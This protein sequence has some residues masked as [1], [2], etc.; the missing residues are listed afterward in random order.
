[1]EV[2]VKHLGL[3][4]LQAITCATKEGARSLRL[5][6][7]VGVI[8]KGQLADVIVVDQDP[9]QDIRVLND[10]H[11]LTAVIS[12]GQSV[13]LEVPWPSRALYRGEKVVQWTGTPLTRELAMSIDPGRP[14]R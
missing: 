7:R 11:R 4:P 1:M 8:S 12:K 5:D 2:L 14:I 13:N 9:L 10:R 3:T 6:G